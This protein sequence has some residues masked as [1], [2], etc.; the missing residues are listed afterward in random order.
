MRAVSFAF[1]SCLLIL[2]SLLVTVEDLGNSPKRQETA[3]LSNAT[4]TT[5]KRKGPLSAVGSPLNQFALDG[6][7]TGELLMGGSMDVVL[8]VFGLPDRIEMRKADAFWDIDLEETPADWIYTGFMLTT[9]YYRDGLPKEGRLVPGPY[10][11]SKKVMGMRV[12]GRDVAVRFGLGLGAPKQ[13]VI[14][15]LGQP[16]IGRYSPSGPLV[17]I[18]RTRKFMGRNIRVAFSLDE[19]GKVTEITWSQEA[20]H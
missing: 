9:H 16:D 11:E 19:Q 6:L 2:P 17:Y 1:H 4:S 15:K 12:H 20:W 18:A 13:I 7:G 5:V 3:D 14:D 10:Y 8:R